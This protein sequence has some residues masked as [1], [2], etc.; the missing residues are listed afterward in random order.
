MSIAHAAIATLSAVMS[1]IAL[2]T[3]HGSDVKIIVRF[4]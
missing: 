3:E 2:E 1:L 4:N